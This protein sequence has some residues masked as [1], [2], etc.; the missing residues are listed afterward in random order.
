MTECS[1]SSETWLRRRNQ[2]FFWYGKKCFALQ[3]WLKLSWISALMTRVFQS[4]KDFLHNLN[5]LPVC[6][7]ISE[8]SHVSRF[9]MWPMPSQIHFNS[10]KFQ[11][12]L[13]FPVLRTTFLFSMTYF[14][15]RSQALHHLLASQVY[16]VVPNTH[17]EHL[18]V[19]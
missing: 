15:L 5:T 13:P 2:W 4:C 8:H 1:T 19:A 3:K 14:S 10:F 6:N 11:F 12:K 9:Q 17:C 18:I 7:Q 16:S